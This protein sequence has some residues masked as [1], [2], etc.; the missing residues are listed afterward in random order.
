MG[1][2][3]AD[4]KNCCTLRRCCCCLGCC[5]CV[6]IAVGVAIAVI[7]SQFSKPEVTMKSATLTGVN[8]TTSKATFH[9]DTVIHIV[10]PNSWPYKGKVKQLT[11]DV[12]SLDK[13]ASDKVGESIYVCQA[14]LPQLVTVNT[15]SETEF[16][17]SADVEIPASTATTSLLLRLNRDCGPLAPQNAEGHKETKLRV[18]L[19]DIIASVADI[20]V[21]MRGIDVPLEILV[22][23][24]AQVP[25]SAPTASAPTVPA[26]TAATTGS[27]LALGA[28][29]AAPTLPVPIVR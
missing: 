17:V 11:A 29:T 25:S 21:D 20:E 14:K 12:W 23:C 3:T 9:I 4:Q 6:V 1:E 22:P 19:S 24:D 15:K 10:N 16:K 8:V 28:T 26:L 2:T 5:C 7:A 13:A 18:K 27:F